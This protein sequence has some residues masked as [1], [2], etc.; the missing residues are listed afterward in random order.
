MELSEYVTALRDELSSITRF[1]GQDMAEAAR[2]LTE[3][4]DPAVRLTLLDVLS[5]AA[6]EITQQLD[7]V[8]IELRLSSGSPDFV[9]TAQP[10]AA[11]FADQPAAAP[12]DGSDDAGTARITLRIAEPLKAR[13]EAAAAAEGISVNSWLVHAALRS[14]DEPRPA[15]PRRGGLGIGQRITGYARS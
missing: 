8:V 9:V 6:A 4:L 13:V 7:D 1:A 12:P 3:A 5:A 2:M 10:G 11:P 15:G 14:L